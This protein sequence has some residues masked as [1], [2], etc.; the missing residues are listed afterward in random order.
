MSRDILLMSPLVLFSFFALYSI[1]IFVL[2]THKGLCRRRDILLTSPPV[3]LFPTAE[4]ERERQREG[5]GGL[6][7]E[8]GKAGGSDSERE[9]KRVGG[10]EGERGR[11]REREIERERARERDIDK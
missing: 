8:R 7:R 2:R 11:G 3:L 10:R 5:G 9:R 6:K 4:R 1:F